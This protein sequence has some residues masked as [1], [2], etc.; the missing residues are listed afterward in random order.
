MSPPLPPPENFN[1]TLFYTPNIVHRNKPETN[2][3]FKNLMMSSVML[4]TVA[5]LPFVVSLSFVARFGFFIVWLGFQPRCSFWSFVA[6]CCF[7]LP[8]HAPSWL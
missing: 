8:V 6:L 5:W 3:N 2:K 1:H 7:P 4:F